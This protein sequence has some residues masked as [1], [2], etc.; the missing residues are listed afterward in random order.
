MS[1]VRRGYVEGRGCGTS[2][3]LDAPTTLCRRK[4]T[5]R[6]RGFDVKGVE[7]TS[8]F[9]VKYVKARA[10]PMCATS[11]SVRRCV[12]ILITPSGSNVLGPTSFAAVGYHRV[13][14]FVT[15]GDPPMGATSLRADGPPVP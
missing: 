8:S 3:G 2:R 9:Y 7:G 1:R 10:Q 6:G 4:G 11:L 5:S 14:E 15:G 13:E 12:W